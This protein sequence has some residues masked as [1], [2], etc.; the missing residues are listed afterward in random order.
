[1]F[2]GDQRAS[3]VTLV[4]WLL[5]FERPSMASLPSGFLYL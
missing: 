4:L 2:L 1:M 5:V 3:L